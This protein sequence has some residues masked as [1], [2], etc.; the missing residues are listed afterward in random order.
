MEIE[1]QHESDQQIYQ[2]YLELFGEKPERTAVTK[3]ADLPLPKTSIIPVC[4][5]LAHGIGWLYVP[6]ELSQRERIVSKLPDVDGVTGDDPLYFFSKDKLQQM[7][8]LMSNFPVK[9]GVPRYI[10][11]NGGKQ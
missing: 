1:F 6:D 9:W 4:I 11:N 3:Q 5:E 10:K 2:T 7:I 8:Y